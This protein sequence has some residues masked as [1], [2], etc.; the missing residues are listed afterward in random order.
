[1]SYFPLSHYLWKMT[2]T[3]TVHILLIL[4]LAYI[5]YDLYLFHQTNSSIGFLSFM[6]VTLSPIIIFLLSIPILIL[7]FL[8]KEKPRLTKILL[9]ATLLMDC[10]AI[11]VYYVNVCM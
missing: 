8:I 6:L 4:N 10:Y 3:K 5:A 1:L 11:Y 7:Y 2:K 9:M